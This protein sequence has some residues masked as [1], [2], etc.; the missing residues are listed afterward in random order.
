[1]VRDTLDESFFGTRFELATDSEQRYLAAM[2]S[3]GDG[4]YPVGA[5]AEA[6]GA[7]DQRRVSVQREGLLQ[8]GL[9]WTPRRGQVDFTV[10]LFDRF[11]RAN[12][13]R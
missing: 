4:P 6:F 11:L 2:A 1:M 3:L 13:P 9:I 10:P 7:R 8:K 5:V 12:H